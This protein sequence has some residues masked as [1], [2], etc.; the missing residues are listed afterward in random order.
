MT[1]TIVVFFHEKGYGFVTGED[2]K[3][4]F[5]HLRE[6]AVGSELYKIAKGGE[7]SFEPIKSYKGCHG[8]NIVLLNTAREKNKSEHA[9]KESSSGN[10]EKNHYET[11]LKTSTCTFDNTA[12]ELMLEARKHKREA[13]FLVIMTVATM[14]NATGL[15]VTKFGDKGGIV[16]MLSF[17]FAVTGVFGFRF[18]CQKS[19]TGNYQKIKRV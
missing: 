18:Y 10:T 3:D 15:V 1:G 11:A 5:I 7:V 17:I 19:L 14:I 12:A 16:L 13:A 4:Y 8:K 6:F 9:A 2:G